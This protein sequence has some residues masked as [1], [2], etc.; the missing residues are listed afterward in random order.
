[1][2][3]LSY[4]KERFDIKLMEIL[5]EQPASHLLSIAG[6]YEV[7]S[8]HFNNDVLT[9]LSSEDEDKS[10]K[11]WDDDLIQFARLLDE[12]VAALD[13]SQIKTLIKDLAT[14]MDLNPDEVNSL[15]DRAEKAWERAKE[16]A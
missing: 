16:N 9:A 13:E 1:M 11:N 6:I 5:D 8:E 15:F 12:I 3:R 14:S 10:H 4:G 7:V 2:G